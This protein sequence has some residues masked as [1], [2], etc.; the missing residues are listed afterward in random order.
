MKKTFLVLYLLFA[1]ISFA[2][3]QSMQWQYATRFG[4]SNYQ[5]PGLGLKILNH[6][7][8][9]EIDAE[10]N[11]YIFGTYGDNA[12]FYGFSDGLAFD[13]LVTETGVAVHL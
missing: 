11:A 10:G 3:A 7:N 4:G 12:S 13:S 5:T 6:P 1:T 9:L 8:H 2:S